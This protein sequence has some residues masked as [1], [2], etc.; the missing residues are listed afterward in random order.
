MPADAA[1]VLGAPDSWVAPA[2][3]A[4][5]ALALG[6]VITFSQDH[7]AAL[8]LLAFGCYAVVAAAVLLASALRADRAIRG[9]A[10]LQGAVT[11]AAA[12]AALALPIGGVGLLVLVVSAWALVSGALEFVNGLRF[13]RIRPAA[14]DWLVTGGLTVLLGVAV[15]LVPQG[16][17]HAFQFEDGDRVIS[18]AVTADIMLVGLLG[19]WAVIAG[20]QLAISAVTLHER[21]RPAEV[22]GA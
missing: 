8:G 13:R 9:I 16:L 3:R 21:P 5:P 15:L 14:R 12:V 18:G 20:V 2:A 19:A 11:A 1:P 7:S 6:L 10:L 22:A 4:L 17:A